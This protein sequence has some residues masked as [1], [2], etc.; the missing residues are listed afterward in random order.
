MLSTSKRQSLYNLSDRAI[1]GVSVVVLA[2]TPFAPLVQKRCLLL[3]KRGGKI[4]FVA[5]MC[6]PN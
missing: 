2:R 6:D 5:R 1:Q 3:W 4:E